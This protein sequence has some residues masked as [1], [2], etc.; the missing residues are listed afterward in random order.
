AHYVA[1]LT[2]PDAAIRLAAAEVLGETGAGEAADPLVRALADA[3]MA[4][5]SQA[6]ESLVRLGDVAVPSLRE[7][8][9]GSNKMVRESAAW[10]L[11]QIGKTSTTG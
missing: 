7:A 2:N 4:V 9:K 10:C 3:D 1:G 6:S 11:Q 8:A 5:V